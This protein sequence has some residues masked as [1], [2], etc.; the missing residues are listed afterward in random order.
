ME[1]KKWSNGK[2]MT[3]GGTCKAAKTDELHGRKV[4]AN[5]CATYGAFHVGSISWWYLKRCHPSVWQG[6]W[7]VADNKDY[8]AENYNGWNFWRWWYVD[9]RKFASKSLLEDVWHGKVM[10]GIVVQ[11]QFVL[12]LSP[13]VF[14]S[15]YHKA[16]MKNRGLV[17]YVKF[18]RCTFWKRNTKGAPVWICATCMEGE[19]RWNGKVARGGSTCRATKTDELHGWKAIANWDVTC[20][21]F[22]AR[23][24]HSGCEA[25]KG[26]T[27]TD[28]LHGWKAIVNRCVTRGVFHAGRT[29]SGC[30]ARK[31]VAKPNILHGWNVTANGCATSGAL[32]AG[33]T[34]SGYEAKK[35]TRRLGRQPSQNQSRKKDLWDWFV[36]VRIISMPNKIWL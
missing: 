11:G 4:A 35:V 18:G 32:H 25:R 2:M 14:L 20:G 8:R 34:H 28:V 3:G 7:H 12:Q 33:C 24:M 36:E 19:K 16:W 13:R 9:E 21:S 29:H 17:L 10:Y 5:G 22:Q 23:R 15:T 30:E 31:N 1:G 27:K 6:N 26:A